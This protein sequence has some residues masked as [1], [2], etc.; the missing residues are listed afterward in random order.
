MA[1][2]ASDRQRQGVVAPVR[3][4]REHAPEAGGGILDE[5][6]GA[7]RRVDPAE[8]GSG[9]IRLRHGRRH[10]ERCQRGGAEGDRQRADEDGFLEH[11]N[12]L[13]VGYQGMPPA[14]PLTVR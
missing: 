1:T 12:S 10:A 7:G 13:N 8:D 14:L 5:D 4:G 9:G 3:I 11:C 2:E 6:G